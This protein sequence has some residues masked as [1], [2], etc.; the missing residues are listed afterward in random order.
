MIV[1]INIFCDRKMKSGRI[2]PKHICEKI[3]KDINTKTIF[4]LNRVGLS[5]EVDMNRAFGFLKCGTA[6][7]NEQNEI[8]SEI[9]F[10][11]KEFYLSHPFDA[12]K[13]KLPLQ[14][15]KNIAK[16]LSLLGG[17]TF[18]SVGKGLCNKEGVVE[19]YDI[20][21]IHSEPK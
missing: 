8:V 10:F 5:E 4:V 9:E 16:L 20:L 11:E 1:G 19:H 21:Y 17:M 15:S 18:H 13:Y 3:I 14:E 6:C 12:Q 7:F 2:F